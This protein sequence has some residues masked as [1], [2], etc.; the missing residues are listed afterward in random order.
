MNI[1]NRGDVVTV[2]SR[3]DLSGRGG[4]AAVVL[5]LW[6]F[7]E[8]GDVLLAPITSEVDCRRYAGFAV[9]LGVTSCKSVGSMLVNKVRMADLSVFRIEVKGR[10]TDQ[11]LSQALS[12]LATLIQ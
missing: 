3:D 11:V 8:L 1:L 4:L 10:V 2:M 6:E 5:S 12:R 9:S 7:N